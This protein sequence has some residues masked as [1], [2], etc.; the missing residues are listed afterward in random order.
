MSDYIRSDS[1]IIT[2]LENK[3]IKKYT[4][5]KQK[6]YRD[7]EKM[8][9]VEG[10]HL[11]KEAEKANALLKIIVINE[12][13]YD[14][15]YK[16]VVTEEIMKKLSTLETP[17]NII[18]V[19]KMM[20]EETILG[21]KI[22]VLDGIQD[23]GNL[24]TI[25][26]SAVAFSICSIILSNDTVDFYHPKVVRATQGMLFHVN[27]IRRELSSEILRLKQSGYCIYTSDV[28]GGEEIRN[29]K[30]QEGAKIALVMGNEGN[31]VSEKIKLLA[32]RKVYIK[33]NSVVESLNVGV[34]TS[35][36]LYEIENKKEEI[37]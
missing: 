29:L 6:K 25:V 28:E 19:C 32:D 37:I 31:G 3:E 22:L 27:I 1:L 16:L 26:R 35:I 21:N 24:G 36:L 18:G 30:F 17:P 13:E 20:E 14:F 5:L 7:L 10:E 34:A 33:M 8:F 9:L 15:S 2:S 11:V 12:E 4:K 23:P